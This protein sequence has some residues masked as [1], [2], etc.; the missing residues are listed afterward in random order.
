M[1]Q[2]AGRTNYSVTGG[3]RPGEKGE[4]GVQEVGGEEAG[5]GI[6]LR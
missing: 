5:N 6:F 3:W 1:R 2:K 4:G